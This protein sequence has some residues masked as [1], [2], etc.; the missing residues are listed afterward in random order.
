MA[1]VLLEISVIKPYACGFLGVPFVEELHK[2]AV[3]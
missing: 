2:N 1:P 3:K